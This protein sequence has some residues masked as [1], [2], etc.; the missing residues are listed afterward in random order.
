MPYE[1][2]I[3]KSDLWWKLYRKKQIWKL[4]ILQYLYSNES[5]WPNKQLAK[6]FYHKES[7]ESALVICRRKNEWEESD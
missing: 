3:E 2:K 1:Y 7:A 5:R 6:I 4:M